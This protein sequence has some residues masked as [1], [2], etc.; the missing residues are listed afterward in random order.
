MN[1]L[2]A[3]NKG[4]MRHFFVML[5][6]LLDNV[7]E[8]LCVYVMHDD[9]DKADEENIRAHF[10]GITFRFI[11]MDASIFDGFPTTKRYPY[12]IYY[13][14]FAPVLLPKEVERV[15]YLDCDLVVH[16]PIDT[17]YNQDFCDNTFVACSHTGA[18]L[19]LINRLRLGVGKGNVYMNTG[20]L[21]M[22]VPKFR[23]ELDVDLLKK[24]TRKSKRRLILFDQ[25]VLYKF[26]GDKVLQ[27]DEKIYNLSDRQIRLHNA[28]HRDKITKEWVEQN[29]VIAH[30]IGKNK[31]W[32]TSYKGILDKYYKRYKK[33]I[34]E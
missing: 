2:V 1:V 24:Y 3:I 20:V 5:A 18:I 26:F 10:Q 13:R 33:R 21:L 31:P 23:A 4:Y 27:A 7:K 11:Y 9:L 29:N 25:D 14:I 30:Y 16:N 34:E 22:N 17:F 8:K 6:S 28:F 32:K 15:L 19:R 12:T